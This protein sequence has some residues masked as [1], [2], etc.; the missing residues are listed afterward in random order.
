LDKHKSD[1]NDG[2]EQH[3]MTLLCQKKNCLTVLDISESLDLSTCE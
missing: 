2:N 3:L 1:D